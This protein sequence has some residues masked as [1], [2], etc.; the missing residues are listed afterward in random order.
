MS[1]FHHNIWVVENTF[2]FQDK[3]NSVRALAW[4]FPIRI[5]MGIQA[6]IKFKMSDLFMSVNIRSEQ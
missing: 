2:A 1:I 3:L 4:I 6:Y 5:Y